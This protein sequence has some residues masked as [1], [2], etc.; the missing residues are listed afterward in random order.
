MN[1]DERAGYNAVVYRALSA[2]VAGN[3]QEADMALTDLLALDAENDEVAA[4]PLADPRNKALMEFNEQRMAALA[5]FD[6]DC[7][8][9]LDEFKRQAETTLAAVHSSD[10]AN[11]PRKT[12]SAR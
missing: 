8:K 12:E 11:S 1:K 10:T 6:A 7:K 5:R 3:R 4:D 2:V 9:S